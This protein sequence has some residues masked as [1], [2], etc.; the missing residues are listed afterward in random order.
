MT[1][2]GEAMAHARRAGGDTSYVI[3]APRGAIDPRTGGGQ[4]TRLFFDACARLGPTDL[5]MFGSAANPDRVR[6]LYPGVRDV[7]CA[8][9]LPRNRSVTGVLRRN[10]RGLRTLVWP[11]GSYGTDPEM[12]AHLMERARASERTVFVY[13]YAQGFCLSGLRADREAGIMVCVDV[14]DRDDQKYLSYLRGVL[15]RVLAD[16]LFEPTSIRRLRALIRSRLREASLVWFAAEE[17]VWDLAPARTEIVP[18]VAMVAAGSEA[19]APASEGQD[20]L[21]VGTYGH[22]PNRRGVQWLLRQVWPR[23]SAACPDARLRVVGI[24]S[25]QDMAQSAEGLERVDL[26]G[27]VEDLGAEYARARVCVCPV[28]EGGGSKIKVIEAGAYARPVVLVPHSARG[29]VPDFAAALDLAA[30]P[31][32]FAEACIAY[33]QDPAR[34]AEAGAAL[35]SVQGEAYAREGLLDR[36]A[37][38]LRRVVQGEGGAP[39]ALG[40]MA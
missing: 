19:V 8:R 21:F 29:F 15:G 16:W 39:A 35:R 12:Q 28:F 38:G 3:V 13:R 40:E 6:S 37:D 25:W 18:N 22:T 31:E 4:R 36:I 32:A 30:T 2:A 26:V 1:E 10:L 24:G 20:V 23:V 27:T 17:D 34:A 14:D 5:V 33:L 9:T 11:A 7:I